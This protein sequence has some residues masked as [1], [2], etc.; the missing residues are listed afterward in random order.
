MSLSFRSSS[1]PTGPSGFFLYPCVARNCVPER[2]INCLLVSS[3]S[4]RCS[5]SLSITVSLSSASRCLRSLPVSFCRIVVWCHRSSALLLRFSQFCQSIPCFFSFLL[6]S[7]LESEKV[8]RLYLPNDEQ[9]N[10]H[11]QRILG[12]IFCDVACFEPI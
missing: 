2:I 3:P 5:T 6:K 12:T 8:H 10:H 9:V 1:F 11:T 4:V 7:R